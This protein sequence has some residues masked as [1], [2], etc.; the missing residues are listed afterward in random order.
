MSSDLFVIGSSGAKAYRAALAAVSE[1]ITNASTAGYSRRTVSMGESAVSSA[2]QVLYK[3]GATFGGVEVTGVNRANDTYLDA[4][5]RLTGNTLASANS[6]LKWQTDME[7]ALSDDDRGVGQTMSSLYGAVTQLAAN[8]TDPSLR[9]NMLFSVEQTVAAFNASAN[10]LKAVQDGIASTAQND[11][12]SLNASMKELGRINTALLR[13]QPGTSNEAQLLDSRDA[14]LSA[15][16]QKLDVSVTFGTNGTA[17]LSY[18]GTVIVQGP[19]ASTFAVAANADG[20]LAL[21]L[22][23][24]A[25][26]APATG[27]LGGAFQSATV[28][29]QR[30]ASLDAL[31]M[32][33]KTDLN[34]WHGQGLTDA[35]AA[36]GALVAGTSAATLTQA[37]TSITDIAAKSTDGTS[38]GNLLNISSIRGN[39]SVEQGWTALVAQNANLLSATKAEQTSADTRDTQARQARDNIS[40]VDLDMEAADLLRLQQAYSASAK[41]IQVARDTVDAIMQIMN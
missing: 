25:V 12:T 21:S 35:G 30:V 33:F 34:T 5:A 13:A 1:N 14:A 9:T 24:S 26:N 31:A 37:I 10:D 6:R 11:V 28:A 32:Q 4:S 23:G 29:T 17:Q 36:G 22:D 15:I 18:N 41:I 7:T 40:G 19:T 16:T 3:S 38:N 20:T 2:T 8:P 27:S 39:G